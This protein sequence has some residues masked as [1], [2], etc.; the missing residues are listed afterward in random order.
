MQ[1]GSLQSRNNAKNTHNLY[2][3]AL[4]KQE[5]AAQ[6]FKLMDRGFKEGV[7]SFIEFLDARNQLTTAQLQLN[8]SKYKFLASLAEYERQTA[9]SQPQ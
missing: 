1:K 8:I 3:S 9:V 5:A 7:N 2:L 6:Y 4:K